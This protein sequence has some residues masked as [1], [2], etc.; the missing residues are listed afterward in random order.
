MRKSAYHVSLLVLLF[1]KG[2]IFCGLVMQ[3][4][5]DKWVSASFPSATCFNDTIY[6]IYF[7]CV[8]ECLVG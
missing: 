7:M 3:K 6:C 4:M 2:V 5:Q 8:I 1:A